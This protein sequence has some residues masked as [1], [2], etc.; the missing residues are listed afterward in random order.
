MFLK[1]MPWFFNILD[2]N[3]TQYPLSGKKAIFKIFST[4]TALSGPRKSLCP[5][6]CQPPLPRQNPGYAIDGKGKHFHL[7]SFTGYHISQICMNIKP[8]YTLF[9]CYMSCSTFIATCAHV[10]HKRYWNTRKGFPIKY[11]ICY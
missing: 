11:I 3:C 2:L 9:Q 5:F 7:F 4:W 10:K 1:I 8:C 6:F